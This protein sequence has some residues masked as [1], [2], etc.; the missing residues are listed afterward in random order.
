LKG[1]LLKILKLVFLF[2]AT[3][4]FVQTVK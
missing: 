1:A 4:I 3:F 2:E